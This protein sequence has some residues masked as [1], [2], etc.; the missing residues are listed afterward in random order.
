MND[1][2]TVVT[3]VSGAETKLTCRVTTKSASSIKPVKIFFGPIDIVTGK[4]KFM[5]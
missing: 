3:A 5:L 2:N 4:G 1:G